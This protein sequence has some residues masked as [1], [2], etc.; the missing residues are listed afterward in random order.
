MPPKARASRGKVCFWVTNSQERRQDGPQGMVGGN[1]GLQS[2]EDTA[3][4][5]ASTRE[6]PKRGQL[7]MQGIWLLDS[8][9]AG[10]DAVKRGGNDHI[11][12]SPKARGL[13]LSGDGHAFQP[14]VH[15]WH[16][17]VPSKKG[18]TSMCKLW[19]TAF[20]KFRCSRIK[21]ARATSWGLDSFC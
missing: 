16:V 10:G 12:N 8:P 21:A 3:R 18:V 5:S 14:T 2:W 15:T 4:P 11:S 19:I 13:L 6:L 1:P 17:Y 9:E 7:I 20:R